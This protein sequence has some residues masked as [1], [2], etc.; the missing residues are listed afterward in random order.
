MM[1]FRGLLFGVLDVFG[2][3]TST[4]RHFGLML[5]FLD[6]CDRQRW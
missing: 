4:S 3:T 6:K 2:T 5:I 1:L